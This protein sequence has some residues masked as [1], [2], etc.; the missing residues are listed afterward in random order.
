MGSESGSEFSSCCEWPCDLSGP[1]FPPLWEGAMMQSKAS[2]QPQPS[3][4]GHLGEPP[5]F[6]A[7]ALAFGGWGAGP[8]LD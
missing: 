5:H 4:L 1:R 6:R 2:D 3:W 8:R 7:S